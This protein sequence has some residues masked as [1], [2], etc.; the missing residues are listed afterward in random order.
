MSTPTAG[1]REPR[2]YDPQTRAVGATFLLRVPLPARFNGKHDPAS[3]PPSTPV[4]LKPGDR[5]RFTKPGKTKPKSEPKPRPP[6]KA[7]APRVEEI[8]EGQREREG[9]RQRPPEYRE[10]SKKAA[11]DWREKAKELGICRD[12]REQGIPSQ[13]RCEACAEKHR[14]RHRQNDSAREKRKAASGGR[15]Q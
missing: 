3:R 12:C 11:K 7:S 13:T 14:V 10:A 15:T 8:P 5:R 6:R 2:P 1:P 4:L 9:P